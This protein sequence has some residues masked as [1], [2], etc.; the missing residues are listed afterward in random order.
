MFVMESF[1]TFVET[2]VFAFMLTFVRVGTALFLMPGIGDSYTPTRV[3]LYI[4]LGLTLMMAPIVS[5][6][7]PDQIPETFIMLSLILSEFV[8]GAFIGLISRILMMALDTAGMMISLQ[9]GLANAQIFNPAFA[10]QGSIFGA[11]L[12][13]SGMMLIFATNLHHL[14]ILG[15][16]HSYESFPIGELPEKGSMAQLAANA[17][18]SAFATGVHI[19]APLIVVTTVLYIGMGVLSRLMP[20]VQVFMLAIPAQ[21]M[22]AFLIIFLTISA[23][24]M[25]WLS[26]YEDGMYFFFSG[27]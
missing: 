10:S 2:G 22:I 26:F 5:V 9:S 4:A 13:I 8:I 12:L 18:S 15:I 17:V 25:Y 14:F 3:R 6:Y 27:K 21:L 7:L 24:L 23:G 11:F 16:M 19:A 20:Q 1:T